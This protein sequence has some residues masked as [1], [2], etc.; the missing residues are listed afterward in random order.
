MAI[1]GA[2]LEKD[3]DF[4]FLTGIGLPAPHSENNGNGHHKE[5]LG[6]TIVVFEAAN[7]KRRGDDRAESRFE[8]KWGYGLKK[9]R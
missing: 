2:E 9:P 7:L 8:A 6:K 3:V 1:A 5:A 4:A